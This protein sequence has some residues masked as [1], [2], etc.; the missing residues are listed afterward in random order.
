MSN[1]PRFL[2]LSSTYMVWTNDAVLSLQGCFDC[3][4][5]EMFEESCE[6]LDE[7]TD[8]VCSYSA[9]CR[10]M[11]IPNKRVKIYPNNKPWVNKSVKSFIMKKQLAFQQGSASDLHAANKELKVDI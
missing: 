2:P 3:T 9:S 1:Q 4:D 11:L 7:L 8:I 6:D 10:D 5:W